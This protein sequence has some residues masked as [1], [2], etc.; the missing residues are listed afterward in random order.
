MTGET[1]TG[2]TIIRMDEG[3]DT[4]PM[5][6]QHPVAI[7]P[8]MDA[9][10]L[11]DLLAHTGAKVIVEGLN[12]LQ[13]NTLTLVAQ[14]SCLATYASKISDEDRIIR[15]GREVGEVHDQIRA[16]TP[17]IGARTFHPDFEGPVKIWRSTILDRMAVSSEIGHIEAENGRIAVYCGRG[18]LEVLELQV[19]GGRRLAAS[20]FLLGNS[21]EG[22]FN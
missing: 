4:G 18:S 9:G 11:T 19:P 8:E 13:T 1:E 20:D 14:D 10:E 6:L 21:L 22:A 2:V 16:L 12:L 15:W 3:L 17:H 5:A 7:P